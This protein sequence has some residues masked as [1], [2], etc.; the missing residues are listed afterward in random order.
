MN[1]LLSEVYTKMANTHVKKKK[2]QHKVTANENHQISLHIT[3]MTTVEKTV[4]YVRNWN[5][6]TL[7]MTM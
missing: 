5:I 7:M 2:G 4:K 6:Y 1:G 3:R